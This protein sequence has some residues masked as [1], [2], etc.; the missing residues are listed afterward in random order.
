VA[1]SSEPSPG[2]TAGAVAGLLTAPYWMMKQCGS[3]CGDEQF[4]LSASLVGLPV[5]G[6]LV[7][8]QPHRSE[9]IVYRSTTT[10]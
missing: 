6:A 2:A 4:M 8:Y 1:R 9:V 7:G 5:A 3:S 10:P